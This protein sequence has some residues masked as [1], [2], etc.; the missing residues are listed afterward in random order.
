MLSTAS[1]FP[2]RNKLGYRS[3]QEVHNRD[4]VSSIHGIAS[5]NIHASVRAA[6]LAARHARQIRE[7]RVFDAVP[8]N[9]M[10]RNIVDLSE[11]N[12]TKAFKD[13]NTKRKLKLH[14]SLEKCEHPALPWMMAQ[15]IE[16]QT[17]SNP[18]F[19]STPLQRLPLNRSRRASSITLSMSS[20]EAAEFSEVA[21]D[22]P[23]E[24]GKWTKRVK[25]L[26]KVLVYREVDR[27]MVKRELHTLHDNLSTIDRNEVRSDHFEQSRFTS[28]PYLVTFYGAFLKP[29]QCAVAVVMEFMDMGSLQD[30]MDTRLSIPE[31]VL[32]HAAFCCVTALDHM[33]SQKTVHRDIKP[34]NILMNRH[35]EFKIADFGLT[36]T[37]AKSHSFFSDFTGTMMYMAPERISGTHYTF[38]SDIWSLGITLFSLATGG[39][40]FT[41]DDG[42]FGLEEAICHDPL[43]PMPNRFSSYCRDF[44][45][46]MLIRDP[47][48]RLTS[49]QALTHPF[50]SGYANSLA[51]RRFS[52]LWQKLGLTRTVGP[53][54][55]RAIVTLAVEYASR[56][57]D[58][59]LLPFEVIGIQGTAALENHSFFHRFAKF[60]KQES[61]SLNRKPFEQLADDCGVSV[62]DLQNIFQTASNS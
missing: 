50:I 57:P 27:H 35:G 1:S 49:E 22:G 12:I 13:K 40:P 34:A 47:E 23:K 46:R 32:R 5:P 16:P 6:A 4:R 61:N 3:E 20:P 38:V 45:K 41:V 9:L 43:H 19:K 15:D 52:R 10:C 11:T 36:G 62:V 14:L 24:L 53:D 2:V 7:K 55:T 31:E 54:D 26:G 58:M 39:N 59:T 8:E 42:F 17:D 60:L 48:H 29:A 51:F 18:L 56:Y 25:K 33:H 21:Y 30:L 44:V 28:C 37:L